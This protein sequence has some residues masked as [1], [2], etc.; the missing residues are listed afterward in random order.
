MVLW[1]K[2]LVRRIEDHG[3]S[4]AR[5][6]DQLPNWAKRGQYTHEKVYA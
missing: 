4:T 6:F 5:V 2:Y 3:I 1:L